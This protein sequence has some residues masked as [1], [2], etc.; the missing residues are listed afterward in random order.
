MIL[1]IPHPSIH[2]R[3]KCNIPY[4]T[5]CFVFYKSQSRYK[6]NFP[7][8]MLFTVVLHKFSS[9]IECIFIYRCRIFYTLS[10]I[11]LQKG[12]QHTNLWII[13]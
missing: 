12:V 9:L 2:L 5:P 4:S 6:Y 10:K 7:E 11:H 3:H 13:N 1:I 8:N